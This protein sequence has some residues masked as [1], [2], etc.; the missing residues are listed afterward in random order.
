MGRVKDMWQDEI[1]QICNDA[2]HGVISKKEAEEK[3]LKLVE[4]QDGQEYFQLI[5]EEMGNIDEPA[6]FKSLNVHEN[7]YDDLKLIAKEDNRTI[8]ATV[9]I[10]TSDARYDRRKNR[11]LKQRNKQVSINIESL[12]KEKGEENV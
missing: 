7:V 3:L 5:E 12:K 9:S 11:Y 6:K 2:I 4:Y 1:D 10:I 8:A